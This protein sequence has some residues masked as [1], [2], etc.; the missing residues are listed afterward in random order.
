LLVF[1]NVGAMTKYFSL[2]FTLLLA[3]S[4]APVAST[5]TD[6]GSS[7]GNGQDAGASP[8]GGSPEV[9]GGSVTTPQPQAQFLPAPTGECPDFTQGQH[10]FTV[11]GKGRNALIWAST[12]AQNAHGPLVFWWHGNGGDPS[13]AT[14]ALGPA[15]QEVVN[16]G[17]AV[18]AFYHDPASTQLP[19]YLSLGGSNQTDLK[20]A[21]EVVGCA[22]QK[23]GIDVARIHSVGFSAGAMHNT[24]FVA[25]R[26]GYLASIV[27]YSGAQL[28]TP[29]EQDPTN[30][31]PA[32]LFYGGST[33]QVSI[34][35]FA[36]YST[37]FNSAL[38]SAGHFSFLCNHNTGHTVPQ[39]GPAAAWKFL[40]AHPF[41]V[42]PEPYANGL[43][44]E[45]PSYCTL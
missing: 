1:I 12:T 45:F 22:I 43:P 4:C 29:T 24:Q 10:T 39:D 8:D 42:T 38:K 32:M 16:E 40:K 15:M 36:T 13:E 37:M 33:D 11:A 9:D 26:S 30:K 5:E 28:T 3:V 23:I 20:Y 25:M 27:N 41:G 18:V 7:S 17:G 2:A 14:F 31:Y 19:W 35:N 21:D 44:P 6:S 34:L